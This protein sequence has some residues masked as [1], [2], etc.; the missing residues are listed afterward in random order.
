MKKYLFIF[1]CLLLIGCGKHNDKDVMKNIKKKNDDLD[2][3]A[4]T[5]ELNMYN[6]ENKYTYSVDVKYKKDDMYRVSLINTVNNHEQIIL[7]NEEG[8]YVLTQ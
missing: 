1:F 4:I 2:S 3:Y 5:G 6:G 7:R 8:V